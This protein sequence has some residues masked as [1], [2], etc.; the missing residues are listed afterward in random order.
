MTKATEA[1]TER[2]AEKKVER[3]KRA[4]TLSRTKTATQIMTR[5]RISKRTLKRYMADPL[6]EA[7]GGVPL[8]FTARGR[9]VQDALSPAEKRTLAA[10]YALHDGGL[11]WIVVAEE[12]GIPIDRLKYLRRKDAKNR[13]RTTLSPAER[14]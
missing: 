3:L 9:P 2:A 14:E 12:L 1:M 7:C 11:K 13:D 5:L 4:A 8:T 6:W 10:A